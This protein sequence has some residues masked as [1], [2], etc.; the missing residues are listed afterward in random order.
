MHFNEFFSMFLQ[1][2]KRFGVIF[3]PINT[4]NIENRKL[5]DSP[6]FYNFRNLYI[7]Q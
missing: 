2:L 5:F 1:V 4:I 7:E 6:N 3:D